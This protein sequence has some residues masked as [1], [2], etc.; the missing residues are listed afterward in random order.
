MS[1]HH[2]KRISEGRTGRPSNH[3][4]HKHSETTKNIQSLRN[5]DLKATLGYK[6]CHDPVTGKEYRLK[7]K[8]LPEGFVW[9]RN[10]E[11]EVENNL[12]KP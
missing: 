6:W 3:T 11:L 8:P 4:G 1:E 9:G 12:K 5:K 7:D 2:I 10:P